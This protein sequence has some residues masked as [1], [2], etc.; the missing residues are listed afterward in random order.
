V[1]ATDGPGGLSGAT[2]TAMTSVSDSPPSLLVCLNA[3]SRTLAALRQ[4]GA[5][6]VNTLSAA[7]QEVAEVFASQRGVEG[8]ARFAAH[9]GWSRQNQPLLAGALATFTCRVAELTEVG[10]H[11]ILIGTVE[12][13]QAGGDGASLVYV[14]RAYQTV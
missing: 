3:T 14:R 11:I 10:S 2:V 13:T 6:T 9:Y 8:E 12:D 4:N 5:F 1:I 7:Q